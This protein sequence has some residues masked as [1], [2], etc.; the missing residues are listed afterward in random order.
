MPQA[1]TFPMPFVSVCNPDRD[2]ARIRNL[3][4]ARRFQLVTCEAD[5]SRYHAWDI[6]D[7]TCRWLPR[8]QGPNLDLSIDSIFMGT[9]I[10][11]AFD[12][13]P[14]MSPEDIRGACAPLL[15]VLQ[16]EKWPAPSGILA[17]ALADVWE[18]TCLGASLEWRMR[19]ARNWKGYIEAF[20]EEARRRLNPV[21]QTRESYLELRR[22]S[23]FVY[24][25]TDL[26]EKANGFEVSE[27]AIQLPSVRRLLVLT[28][29]LID[30]MND[31]CS[32]EREAA[33]GDVHNLVL[34]MQ[35]LH[36]L[37]REEAMS[38]AQV[39]MW[40]WCE[41]FSQVE[42]RLPEDCAEHSL[43]RA[44]TEVLRHLI[45]GLKEGIGGHP[46]WYR[47][48]SRYGLSM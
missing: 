17:T 19:A 12:D 9:V 10:E 1:V 3:D 35:A 41:E 31:V 32:A 24:V 28:A 8:A 40:R 38:E 48:T 5:E 45:R 15:A 22:Q 42:A 13:A 27:R 2:A 18:R 16:P 6:T 14:G 37:S 11:E 33:R 20:A 47:D 7:L 46:D 26:T 34:I 39:C 29:D 23:G 36:G 21:P 43:T 30:T 25:M 4:W 44:E